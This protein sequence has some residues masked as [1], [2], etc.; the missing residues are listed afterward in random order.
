MPVARRQGFLWKGWLI[1]HARSGWI[2]GWPQAL[3][4]RRFC[5]HAVSGFQLGHQFSGQVRLVRCVHEERVLRE[6]GFRPSGVANGCEPGW[7]LEDGQK[8]GSARNRVVRGG[9]RTGDLS[10]DQVQQRVAQLDLAVWVTTDA[11]ST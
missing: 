2:A 9:D 10:R 5:N 7:L 4:A 8:Q 6:W 11:W 3:S 1:A